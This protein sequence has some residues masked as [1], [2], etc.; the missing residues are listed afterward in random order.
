MPAENQGDSLGGSDV[1]NMDRKAGEG[2]P[3]KTERPNGAEN[4]TKTSPKGTQPVNLV[5]QWN[6]KNIRS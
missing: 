4:V 6:G 1:A 3:Q 5:K 2:R